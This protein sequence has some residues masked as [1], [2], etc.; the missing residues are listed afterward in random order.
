MSKAFEV[1]RNTT[2]QTVFCLDLHTDHPSSAEESGQNEWAENQLDRGRKGCFAQ[3]G[4]RAVV[5]HTS[6]GAYWMLK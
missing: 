1:F 5:R 4:K 6:Q 3:D 2:Q